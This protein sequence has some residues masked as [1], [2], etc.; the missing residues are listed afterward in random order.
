VDDGIELASAISRR[1]SLAEEDRSA[2]GDR[3]RAR[4]VDRFSTS[5]LGARTE[6]ILEAVAGRRSLTGLGP[7]VNGLD[8]ARP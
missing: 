1:L 5:Q 4:I 3:L 7:N 6:E 8:D 2:L